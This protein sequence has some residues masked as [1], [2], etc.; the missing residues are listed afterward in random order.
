MY[1]FRVSKNSL[2]IVIQEH[3]RYNKERYERG[4]QMK[5][6]IGLLLI[7]QFF[8]LSA[9]QAN[10]IHPEFLFETDALQLDH[11]MIQ[12]SNPHP[13]VETVEEVIINHSSTTNPATSSKNLSSEE[14]KEEED[15]HVDIDFTTD[16]SNSS[17]P[18]EDAVDH[19][20]PFTPPSQTTQ[21][22]YLEN[23]PGR[24]YYE[25]KP[26]QSPSEKIIVSDGVKDFA[27]LQYK[28]YKIVEDQKGSGRQA[29]ALYFT[30]TNISDETIQVGMAGH[31]LNPV[32][33]HSVFYGQD[34]L[35][36]MPSDDEW[37]KF[38][39]ADYLQNQHVVFTPT[40]AKVA[41]CA[42]SKTLKPGKSR[43]CYVHYSYPGAGEYLINQALDPSYQE[44]VSFILE[45]K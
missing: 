29:I 28:T 24:A 40:D 35:K 15:L 41:A 33:N 37:L 3:K 45:V 38:A 30:E 20:L 9:C 4:S 39:D 8:F 22:I 10:H 5:L 7:S 36:K 43:E 11:K 14:V 44:F 12:T 19:D 34:E 21:T 1:F 16:S 26:Y 13:V 18:E 6:F 27:T 17:V 2:L 31:V 23:G 32:L 42:E 25:T